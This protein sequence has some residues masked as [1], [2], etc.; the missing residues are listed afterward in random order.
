M[1]R[2]G[3]YLACSE[4]ILG[5]GPGP[6]QFVPPVN[7]VFKLV[8]FR[9]LDA[10]YLS[11][12]Y[13]DPLRT[14]L[15]PL[16]GAGKGMTLYV[17]YKLAGFGI[18]MD[19]A[20]VVRTLIN[21]RHPSLFVHISLTPGHPLMS[22]YNAIRNHMAVD[23]RP[24]ANDPDMS[25]LLTSYDAAVPVAR[26]M[27]DPPRPRRSGAP[28]PKLPVTPVNSPMP[29]VNSMG[30]DTAEA[31]D[32]STFM[33][34]EYG[35]QGYRSSGSSTARASSMPSLL[36]QDDSEATATTGTST[37]SSSTRMTN[38]TSDP[39]VPQGSSVSGQT[40][41]EAPAVVN[42][43]VVVTILGQSTRTLI[44]PNSFIDQSLVITTTIPGPAFIPG[45]GGQ[46]LVAY[47]GLPGV[48]V[49]QAMWEA[50]Q[51]VEQHGY[52]MPNV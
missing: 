48:V 33:A 24:F 4:I 32:F 14:W 30:L 23:L 35:S 15:I 28:S 5:P 19:P 49:N 43:S 13:L 3:G 34:E 7:E 11:V 50:I 16:S 40:Q 21:P 9:D 44:V 46:A 36:T 22:S 47:M 6:S 25:I 37:T 42:T 45:P 8:Y 2:E 26:Y 27:N 10:A 18:T 52:M 51:M 31:A 29:G 12:A 41:V 39:L 38:S 17:A 20:T 1:A